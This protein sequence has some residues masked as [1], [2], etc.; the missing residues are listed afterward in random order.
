MFIFG[1]ANKEELDAIEA[2][3]HEVLRV[4]S[5][6]DVDKF[7]EPDGEMTPEEERETHPIVYVDCNIHDFLKWLESSWDMNEIDQCSLTHPFN[8]KKVVDAG[9]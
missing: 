2:M 7:V 4:A 5:A 6:D 9:Q 1:A 8:E 3:G